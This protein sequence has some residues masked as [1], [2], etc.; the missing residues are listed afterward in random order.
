[1]GQD[2]LADLLAAR[3]RRNRPT[4]RLSDEERAVFAKRRQAVEAQRE[5]ARREV[6]VAAERRNELEAA[7]REA[8]SHLNLALAAAVESGMK[9]TPLRELVGGS[10]ATFWRRVKAAREAVAG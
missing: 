3:P 2:Q 6:A 1:M 8:E 7:L 9:E 5:Q 10:H 4:R